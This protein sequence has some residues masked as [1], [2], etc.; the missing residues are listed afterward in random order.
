ML[1]HDNRVYG[2]TTGQFTPTSPHGFHGHSTPD[3]AREYPFNPLDLM[4]TSG[5]S[6]IARAYTHR[7]DQLKRVIREAIGHR[8]FSFVDIIQICDT[9]NDMTAYYDARVYDWDETES[10]DYAKAYMKTREWDYNNDARIG[11]GIMYRHIAPTFEESYP[12]AL[13]LPPEKRKEWVRNF[14]SDRM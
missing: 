1:V 11:L 8:G 5:A 14:M 9:Y 4:L 7:R 12:P 2:L 13:P 6:F 10:G 3:G